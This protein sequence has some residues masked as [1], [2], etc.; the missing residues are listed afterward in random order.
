MI[1]DTLFE[2]VVMVGVIVSACMFILPLIV[3][4]ILYISN[5]LDEFKKNNKINK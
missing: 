4:L 5:Y 2:G 3:E 1:S